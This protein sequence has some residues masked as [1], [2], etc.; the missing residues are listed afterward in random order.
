MRKILDQ[1]NDIV[2][3]E[4]YCTAPEVPDLR[5]IGNRASGDLVVEVSEGISYCAVIVPSAVR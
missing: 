3:K 2:T 5:N 4:S 1:S